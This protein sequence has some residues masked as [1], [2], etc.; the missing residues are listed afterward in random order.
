MKLVFEIEYDEGA[1]SAREHLDLS[2]DL[3]GVACC[4]SRLISLV[5]GRLS[6]HD[7]AIA[8]AFK[9]VMQIGIL[10]PDSPVFQV[11]ESDVGSEVDISAVMPKWRKE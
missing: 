9:Q 8:K 4:C 3:Q 5:Y 11:N 7:P 10:D 1:D 2:G 6:R